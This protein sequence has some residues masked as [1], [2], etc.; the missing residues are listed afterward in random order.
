MQGSV[1][2]SIYWTQLDPFPPAGGTVVAPPF[3]AFPLGP[4]PVL[5]AVGA[6]TPRLPAYP[7]MAYPTMFYWPYP[8][9]PVSPSSPYYSSPPHLAT[10]ATPPHHTIIAQEC[11][12]IQANGD[13]ARHNGEAVATM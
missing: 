9:P 1:Y 4:A 2:A 8:S 12:P 3:G 5:S 11:I 10:P 6:V 7:G 13:A